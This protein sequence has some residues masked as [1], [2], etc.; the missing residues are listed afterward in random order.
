ML[1]PRGIQLSQ[2]KKVYIPEI[3][4]IYRYGSNEKAPEGQILLD[5]RVQWGLE[6]TTFCLRGRRSNQ[7]SYG[8]LVQAYAPA[9]FC[10]FG[11]KPCLPTGRFGLE[12]RFSS[13]KLEQS[14]CSLV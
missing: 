9:S 4:A 7:L 5:W 6:P 3:S 14:L 11:K 1:F 2:D 8:T 12:L 10:L 13:Q